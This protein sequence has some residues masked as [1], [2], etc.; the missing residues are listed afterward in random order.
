MAEPTEIAGKIAGMAREVIAA[1]AG[2]TGIFRKLME[3][4]GEVKVIMLRLASS[5][6]PDLRKEL[7]PIF[8]AEILAHA[9]GEEEELYPVLLSFSQTQAFVEHSIDEHHE[10]EDLIDKLWT[11]DV[12]SAQWKPLFE[13]IK[14]SIEDH[15]EDEE[16][17]MFPRAR[18]LIDDEEANRIKARY[19]K[20]KERELAKRRLH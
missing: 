16:N 18:T 1:V 17:E 11:V 2:Y 6:N 13:E 4:H 14:L 5:D 9:H 3:E 7:F 15:V 20:V 8:R 10:V 12:K 19:L